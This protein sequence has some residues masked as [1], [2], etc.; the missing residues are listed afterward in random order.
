MSLAP[1][2]V[3]AVA[4]SGGR[5]STAL[6]HATARA[7]Q[8]LGLQVV[9]L[10]VHH[11]LVPQADGWVK[12]LRRQ[13]RRWAVAGL[14][15]ALRVSYLNGQP[16]AGDSVEAWARKARY[17]ALGRMAREA[18]ASVVLLAHHEQD[19]AETF[20][21]QALR[22]GSPAG[23]SAMPASAVRNG[24]TWLRP[25]LSQPR[26]VIE[27]YVRRYRL[28]F[29]D[30][31]SNAELRFAR[32][33]LRL[34]VMP[35]LQAA[36]PTAIQQLAAAARRQQEASAC[37]QELAEQDAQTCVSSEGRV[38]LRA[39]LALSAARRSHLLRRWLQAQLPAGVPE[40][41]VHRLCQELPG[42]RSG[43]RWPASRGWVVRTRSFLSFE[44]VSGVRR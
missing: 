19:Q 23:L 18:G 24:L 12:H 31:E 22:M 35:H 38:V 28:R 14:P 34:Q 26:S 10:H 9:A 41:L 42:S 5:D 33:R 20:L 25:W 32:N 2:C 30:D 1:G 13:T 43:A 3:V 29:V 6:L 44:P 15:V 21:L 4:T 16:G 40:T 36:F 27:A 8:P 39:W 7:A 37:L 17:E 11:G